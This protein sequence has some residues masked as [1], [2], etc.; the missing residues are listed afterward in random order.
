MRIV[1][2]G[3]A[4]PMRGGM[5]HY[6]GLLYE[7]LRKRGHEVRILSFKRQ[8]PSLFFPGTTQMDSSQVTDP[9]PC[10]PLL[11]SICPISWI[12]TAQKIR[13]YAPDLVIF[14]YWMP[15][16]LP[17]YSSVALLTRFLTGARILFICHNIIPHER[18][19]GDR[20]LTAVGFRLVDAFLVHSK[21]V[22]HDL[23]AVRPKAP[24]KLVPLP[25]FD[26]FRDHM[27]RSDARVKLGI[28]QKE[29]VILFFG[30][31]RRYK[32]LHVA[33]RAMAKLSEHMNAR[34][35]IAGEFYEKVDEYADEISD[36]GLEGRVT[37]VNKYVPN[38]DVGMYF[39]AADVVS[40]PYLTTTQSGI[41]PIAYHFNK[42]VIISDVG[43]LPEAVEEGKTGFVIPANDPEALAVAI[44]R[45][46]AAKDH[47]DFAA[48]IAAY[49]KRFS[50]DHLVTALEC[51]AEEGASP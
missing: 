6:L 49:K 51:L 29:I 32:G 44:Q 42:P 9:V 34:L 1:L 38:E 14:N 2:V 41:L 26:L 21:S 25:I 45:F 13:G 46:A 22:Q 27:V 48:H 18:R 23:L 17:C 40:L 5:A 43:G 8:Y 12:R 35:L 24:H 19:V 28:G 33:I 39:A 16:F 47:T 15:F 31:V 37:V 10:E 36:L 3:T 4:H 30:H 7:S 50:W 20:F 11:D